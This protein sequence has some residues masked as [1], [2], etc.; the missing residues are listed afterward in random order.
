MVA[1][2]GNSIYTDSQVPPYTKSEIASRSSEVSNSEA[3]GNINIDRTN[4]NI[5][6]PDRVEGIIDN[7]KTSDF[8]LRA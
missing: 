6:L 7:S 5:S 2:G 8:R 1:L 4:S 3:I